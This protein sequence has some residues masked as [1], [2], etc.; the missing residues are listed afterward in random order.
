M[1]NIKNIQLLLCKIEGYK[2]KFKNLHWS[3]TCINE[4]KLL[5]K[6][7]G[8]VNTYEDELAEISQGMT[9]RFTSNFLYADDVEGKD[10]ESCIN[11]L[12]IDLSSTKTILTKSSICSGLVG[13]TEDLIDE[14]FK[15]KYLLKMK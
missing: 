15:I 4:H 7:V 12:I 10:T 8:L 11:Y 6:I 14:L 9:K 3:S 13:K 1:D 2:I 5:D